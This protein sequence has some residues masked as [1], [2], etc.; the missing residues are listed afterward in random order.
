MRL[1]KMRVE[2]RLRRRASAVHDESEVNG[3]TP[4]LEGGVSRPLIPMI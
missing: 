1:W 2:P 4:V 3:S